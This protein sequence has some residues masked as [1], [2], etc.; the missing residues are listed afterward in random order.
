MVISHSEL[1]RE[2]DGFVASNPHGYH[3]QS[4]LYASLRKDF[5]Y[6][7]ARAVIRDDAGAI[8]GGAQV[9]YQVTP[10]GRLGL[11]LRGPIASGN[12]PDIF[13]RVASELEDLAWQHFLASIRVETF[14]AQTGARAALGQAGYTPST[15]WTD[16]K[17]SSF[18]DLSMNDED[19]LASLPSATRNQV[20]G[21]RRKGV[22]VIVGGLQDVPDFYDMLIKTAEYQ[23]FPVFPLDYFTY[24][25]E[26]FGPERAPIFIAKHD[27]KP[28]SAVMCF[29]TGNRLYYC[30]GGMDRDP[31]LRKLNANR[32][33]HFEAMRWGHAMGL[34]G[35][36]LTG[37]NFFKNQLGHNTVTWPSVLRRHFGPG[38]SVHRSIVEGTSRSETLREMVSR[39]AR[40]LGY[41]PRM[42]Y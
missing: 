29:V 36:D 2:W 27:S 20:R 37:S 15:A 14:P 4:S 26:V 24:M 28:I 22:Q 21:A 17:E 6:D 5:G 35:Y 16:K 7:C 19:I 12:D 3:E 38:K 25:Q 1:D 40:R 11:V 9:L 31:Q 10:A 13:A 23:G 30:W 8:I 32:L 42:P 18:V 39:G 34:D 41:Q 33:L